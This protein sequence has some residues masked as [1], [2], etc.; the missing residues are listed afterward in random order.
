MKKLS[1]QEIKEQYRDLVEFSHG[2]EDYKRNSN[3][4]NYLNKV[5]CSKI[6]VAFISN[7]DRTETK[8]H[9]N[10]FGLGWDCQSIIIVNEKEELFYLSNSEWA[11]FSV[12]KD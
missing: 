3:V 1:V 10:K 6:K 2:G 9:M 11:T 12:L 4:R 5:F 8:D 7:D